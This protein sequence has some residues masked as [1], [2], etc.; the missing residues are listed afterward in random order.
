MASAPYIFQVPSQRFVCNR[1]SRSKTTV[2]G[3]QICTVCR[4]Y[5]LPFRKLGPWP[6]CRLPGMALFCF[7]EARQHSAVSTRHSAKETASSCWPNRPT[8]RQTRRNTL[9]AS[10]RRNHKKHETDLAVSSLLRCPGSATFH[11]LSAAGDFA[12]TGS[13]HQRNPV[14][15]CLPQSEAQFGPQVPGQNRSGRCRPAT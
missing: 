3:A 8:L 4:S 7:L 15:L 11:R 2:P 5:P 6:G 13:K 9:R 12:E 10:A 14:R 1:R